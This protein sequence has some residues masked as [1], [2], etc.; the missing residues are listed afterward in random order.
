M[1]LVEIL[2]FDELRRFLPLLL[3]VH[4]ELDGFWEEGI[5]EA[6]FV[7]LLTEQFFI[8]DT[9]FYGLKHENEL[10]YFMAV[11]PRG[12]DKCHF[13]LLY[14]NKTK[15]EYSN[16][17]VETVLSELKR[18]GYKKLTF[19]TTRMTR[20]YDRW[21]SKFGAQKQSLTYQISL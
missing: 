2:T 9:K 21:V 14:V 18:L 5:N 1:G 12:V 10:F 6:D 4:K 13:W 20:S 8:K 16:K 3:K 15:R 17:L 19:S 7:A 11:V